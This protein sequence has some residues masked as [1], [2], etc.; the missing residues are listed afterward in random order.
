MAFSAG[1]PSDFLA[2]LAAAETAN[3][4][5]NLSEPVISPNA[6]SFKSAV[7]T[8]STSVFDEA[9]LSPSALPLTPLTPTFPLS[10]AVSPGPNDDFSTKFV[11]LQEDYV[12]AKSTWKS[13]QWE[14]ESQI[15]S[16]QIELEKTR[17][18]KQIAQNL[19][20]SSDGDKVGPVFLFPGLSIFTFSLLDSARHVV[21][22]NRRMFRLLPLP[23]LP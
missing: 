1:L 9:A 3:A 23:G 17:E 13:L 10:P 5:S 20:E 4:N 18:E 7:S 8:A 19:S 11:A 6:P 2:N 14:L 15:R 12:K 16:L 21:L 22:R